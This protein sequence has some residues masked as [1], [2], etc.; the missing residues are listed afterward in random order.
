[1]TEEEKNT[2][3]KENEAAYENVEEKIDETQEEI[4][5]KAEETYGGASADCNGIF[6]GKFGEFLKMILN[7]IKFAVPIL[8]IGLSIIDFIKAIAAQ[9]D[10]DLK[11][12]ANKLT[13]RMIIGVIIFLLPTLIEFILKLADINSGTCGI[14]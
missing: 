14:R 13:K 9:D 3:K 6:G 10:K 2:L 12:A 1:M 4:K 11:N 8:I 7:L 5:D